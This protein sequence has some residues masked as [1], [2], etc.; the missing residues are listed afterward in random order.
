VEAGEALTATARI[1][2]ADLGFINRQ[3]KYVV[4]PGAFG[5]RVGNETVE[6]EVIQ[7]NK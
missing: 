3:N 4:E 2:V 1:P 7:K 5:I 6:I